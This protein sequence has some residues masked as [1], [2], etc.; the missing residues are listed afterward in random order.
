MQ[1]IDHRDKLINLNYT[2]VIS[3]LYH[4]DLNNGWFYEFQS[5]FMN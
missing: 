2:T 1:F 5:T 3:R 4:Y